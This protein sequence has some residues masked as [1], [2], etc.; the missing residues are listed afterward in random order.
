MKERA[1]LKER[2]REIDGVEVLIGV[3]IGVDE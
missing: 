3:E 2:E 1:T